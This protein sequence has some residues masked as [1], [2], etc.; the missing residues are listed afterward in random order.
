MLTGQE[1][2]RSRRQQALHCGHSG[3]SGQRGR[4]VATGL[5]EDTVHARQLKAL[6][7]R[8]GRRMSRQG[9]GRSPSISLTHLNAARPREKV[10]WGPALREFENFVGSR[11]TPACNTSGS[12]NSQSHARTR[13]RG[14]ASASRHRRRIGY[15]AL[16]RSVII[17]RDAQPRPRTALACCVLAVAPRDLTY[18]RTHTQRVDSMP[19]SPLMF[20]HHALSSSQAHNAFSAS[21]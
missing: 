6:C 7:R 15:V 21:R 19:L 3:K 8:V 16:K 4:R 12:T 17:S 13:R 1:C 2:E 18:A 20:A 14:T 9:P 5:V 11:F 10:E